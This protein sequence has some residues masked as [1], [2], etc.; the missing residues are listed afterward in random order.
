MTK[1]ELEYDRFAAAR[2]ALPAP[3][4]HHFDEATREVKQLEKA[5]RGERALATVQ[6]RK[7]P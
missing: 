5:R 7:K 1:A 6:D 4:E 2:S 3:V